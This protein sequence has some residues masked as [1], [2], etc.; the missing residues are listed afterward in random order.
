MGSNFLAVGINGVAAEY[1]DTISGAGSNRCQAAGFA[2][3]GALLGFAFAM[4]VTLV[5]FGKIDNFGRSWD[6]FWNLAVVMA[7]LVSLLWGFINRNKKRAAFRV[8]GRA[9][10]VIIFVIVVFVCYRCLIIFST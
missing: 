5:V 7:A 3:L 9:L 6:Y 10:A 2:C 4:F 1:V 8:P